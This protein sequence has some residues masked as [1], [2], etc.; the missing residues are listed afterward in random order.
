MHLD[1]LIK[2]QR[3]QGLT[4]GD[5]INTTDD[6][7]TPTHDSHAGEVPISDLSRDEALNIMEGMGITI[8]DTMYDQPGKATL[9]IKLSTR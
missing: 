2:A 6:H 4:D 3:L 5:S 7:L 8:E 1:I 9:A